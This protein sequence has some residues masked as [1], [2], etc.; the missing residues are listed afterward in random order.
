MGELP[1][2]AGTTQ[3]TQVVRNAVEA[4]YNTICRVFFVPC[5]NSLVE[6]ELL[7]EEVGAYAIGELEIY[8]RSMPRMR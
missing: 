5:H 2:W 8:S 6:P 7:T 4:G 1:N 3:A